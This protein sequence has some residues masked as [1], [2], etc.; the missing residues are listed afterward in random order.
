MNTFD[1]RILKH[2]TI[3]KD[4]E[5]EPES[6]GPKKTKTTLRMQ[7]FPGFSI[8][9]YISGLVRSIISNFKFP[10]AELSVQSKTRKS[11]KLSQL[12]R[13]VKLPFPHHLKTSNARYHPI[14]IPTSPLPLRSPEIIADQAAHPQHLAEEAHFRRTQAL[15]AK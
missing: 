2:S 12:S 7:K 14:I 8:N 13:F 4:F 9:F 3:K 1:V 6:N 11:D 10:C 5:M 15:R